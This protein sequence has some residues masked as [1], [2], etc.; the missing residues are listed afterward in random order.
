V[1]PAPAVFVVVR[2]FCAAPG[3]GGEVWPFA[4]PLEGGGLGVDAGTGPACQY[5][6]ALQAARTFPAWL[7]YWV[8]DCCDWDCQYLNVFHA[9]CVCL[10]PLATEGPAPGRLDAPC[11]AGFPLEV[12]P[13]CPGVPRPAFAD[14][15]REAVCLELAPGGGTLLDAV[16]LPAFCEA[17]EAE[18]GGGADRAALAGVPWLFPAVVFRP[19]CACGPAGWGAVVDGAGPCELTRPAWQP[20]QAGRWFEYTCP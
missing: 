3:L 8:P 11:P 10:N 19:A 7:P 18:A 14:D 12:A 1:L 15:W 17:E 4:A 5:F 16:A 20:G 2:V 6:Q 9:C 13:P